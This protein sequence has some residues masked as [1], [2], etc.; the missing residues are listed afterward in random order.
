MT[1]WRTSPA[2]G[3]TSGLYGIWTPT[4]ATLELTLPCSNN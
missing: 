2:C 4:C 1:S 3:S